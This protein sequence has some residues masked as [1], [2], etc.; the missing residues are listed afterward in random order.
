LRCSGIRL[1]HSAR[2]FFDDPAFFGDIWAGI[3]D[4][5]GRIDDPAAAVEFLA[6]LAGDGRVLELAIGTDRVALPLAGRGIAVEGV[7]A[8]EAMVERPRAKPRGE[9]V[10]VAIG[11]MAD[12]PVS[13]RRFRD[14]KADCSRRG[15]AAPHL[16]VPHAGR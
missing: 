14:R 16:P 10:P 4:D 6:G 13:G 12:V 15:R 3:Y 11:D 8:P 1:Q 2:A 7:D 9:S 5:P